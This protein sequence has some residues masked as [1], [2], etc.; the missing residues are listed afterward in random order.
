MCG[1]VGAVRTSEASGFL[2]EGLRRLEYRGYD[3]AGVVVINPAGELERARTVGKVSELEQALRQAPLAGATGI[4]HTRWATHGG[5][6]KPN[7]HPHICNGALAL[8]CNGIVEN[9]ESLRD[10][11]RAAG[12]SFTSETDTEVVVH[13]VYLHLQ[14]GL[15]LAA[16][17][18][19]TMAEL[20]GSFALAVVHA[21][22]PARLVAARQGP[23]LLLGRAD[24]ENFVASDINA[25]L[26]VTR[27]YQVLENGDV[28]DIRGTE[29]LIRDRAGQVVERAVHTSTQS[30]DS[31]ELGEYRHFMQKEIHEQ[32][33][34]VAD[35]L[36][37]RLLGDHV[38][39]E[40]FGTRAR[41]IFETTRQIQI[42]ACGTSYH[43]GLVAQHWLEYVGIPCEVEVASE[44]RYRRH[45]PR[46]GTL[47][48][49]ISQS[50][51]TADTLAALEEATR[52]RIAG[53]LVI[54]NVPE[55][56]L[57][58]ESD[59]AFMTHCGPEVGVASTKTFVSAMTG[60]LLLALVLSRRRGFD[61]G[62]EAHVV[63][64]IR[65][66]PA[67]LES[68]LTM[69]GAVADM[70]RVFG[71]KEHA[72]FLGRGAHF[73]IAMEGALKLKEISYIHAEAYPAGELKHGP[74]ALVDEKMPVVAVAPNDLLIEKLKSNLE[75]VRARGGRLFLFA[76]PG[77]G[78]VE[79]EDVR[80]LQVA[81]VDSAIAPIIY[82]VPLQLLSY[83]VALI[84]GTDVDKPR[85]LAKSVTVE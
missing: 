7:A 42:I 46:E 79:S 69:E 50:G 22:E 53:S 48:V 68:V 64:Q 11:Q 44:Y 51:E 28:A 52:Q 67:A 18:R 43:A 74:L 35:T 82:T 24:G 61:A 27:E 77:S 3:S 84:K 38:L 4:A 39:E 75:E 13:Q 23:P 8:V 73:P 78:L 47:V 2:L 62:F 70:A 76:D 14:D 45:A 66:L 58:R 29:C 41:E 19:A 37:G 30:G 49:T 10:A 5:V 83:H 26:T 34:A 25:L 72:L 6:T 1:I 40:S 81:P 12:L 17:V 80:I 33:R 21:G 36:E 65:T 55:S 57:V 56:S 32:P 54:C 71:D 16:A 59:L 85:N 63:R 15:D 9:H 20:H 31:A 60:L